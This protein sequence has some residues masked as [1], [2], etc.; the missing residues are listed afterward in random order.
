M[1]KCR[2]K[3]V[4]CPPPP[5]F[6]WSSWLPASNSRSP[7]A[8]AALSSPSAPPDGCTELWR[9][10]SSFRS[11]LEIG[12][13]KLASLLVLFGPSAAAAA[14]V[15]PAAERTRID[16]R[17]TMRGVKSSTPVLSTGTSSATAA[18]RSSG[19]AGTAIAVVAAGH[20]GGA[21]VIARR[22]RPEVAGGPAQSA[23]DLLP[24]SSADGFDDGDG[25]VLV[26]RGDSG[27]GGRPGGGQQSPLPTKEKE[28]VC[29]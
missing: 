16:V 21:E 23:D 4:Q 18:C 24:A 13:V 17:G 5:R 2:T 22:Q 14:A 3:V 9:E 15:A 6:L 19:S 25:V 11:A 7:L 26:G 28:G 1:P 8:S 12:V 29:C 27:E 10:N 20:S